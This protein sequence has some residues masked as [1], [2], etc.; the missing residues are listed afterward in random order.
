MACS[1]AI[2]RRALE[3]LARPGVVLATSGIGPGRAQRLA[4]D[5]MRH[6][7]RAIVA[8]GFCGAL[9]G[10][11]RVGDTLAFDR[12]V[13]SATGEVYAADPALLA[14]AGDLR[15]GTLVSVDRIVRTPEGRA[16]LDGDAVDMESAVLAR[17]AREHGVPFLAV[18]AVSDDATEALPDL[19][20]AIDPFGRPRALRL[21]GLLLRDP[22][23]VRSLARL[24]ASSRQAS[25]AL[26]ASVGR[27][28]DAVA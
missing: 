24:S 13:D 6:P 8:A 19:A 25:A 10:S 22:G 7:P 17:S 18:R 21:A 15:R 16:A 27:L 9:S 2:E 5:L 12:V 14:A 23:S 20:G 11:L 3:G 28:L 4:D 1:L 26:R